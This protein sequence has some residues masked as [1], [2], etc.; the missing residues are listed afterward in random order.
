M[1]TEEQAKTRREEIL[2]DQAKIQ[3]AVASLDKQR[4]QLQNNFVALQGA[5]Q[6]VDFFLGANEETT[7]EVTEDE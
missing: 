4:V 3:E 6:Q 1:I 7:E 2:L 5:L